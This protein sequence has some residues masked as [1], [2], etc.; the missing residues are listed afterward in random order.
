MT[1]SDG[2]EPKARIIY[3]GGGAHDRAALTTAFAEDGF[4]LIPHEG[5]TAPGA[6]RADIG[7]IDLRGKN[8]SSRKAQSI[9]AY[10][11][12][13]SPESV[14]LI[15]I[16]PYI[17][18]AA[19][20]ALRRHGELVAMLTKPE[21]LIERCRHVLRLRNI[22]E[23]SGE[24]L[25]TLATLNR[26]SDFP[27]ITAPAGPLSV[28]I[29]GEAGPTALAALNAMGAVSDHCVCVFS[30]GQALRA[31]E[32]SKF[33]C[34]VFLPTRDSDPLLGL[35]RSLR[36]HP[37][38]ATMPVI[39]P[40]NDPDHAADYVRR[41]AADFILSGHVATDLAI[42]MQLA[43]RRARLAKAM[44]RFL[45]ACAGDSVRDASSGA[46]TGTFLAEHGARLCSRA[47]QSGRRMSMIALRI[48]SSSRDNGEPEPGKRALHQAAHLINR[49]TRAEDFAARIAS[50]TFFIVMP[51]TR[52]GDAAKAALR[53]Q[54][55][56]EN[57]LFRSADDKL[58]Y[59]MRVEAAALGR[60]DGMS[61]E[62]CV[63]AGLNAL[64]DAAVTPLS[65]Q[66]PR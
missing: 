41:G 52:E 18:E 31:A 45:Q 25:K 47:D 14:I 12:K 29:A 38:H 39:F 60:D 6:V 27:P 49:V 28:L 11:R 56:L 1:G 13:I 58:L 21:G 23:E 7:L 66:S 43:A 35:A 37:K 24:R 42:K 30:A 17:G 44:R 51:A 62:E 10:L 20:K 3:V 53:V 19:R 55:V 4:L 64:K 2:A 8:V 34:A 5:A 48:R 54:A 50:D 32:N 36:R 57:T 61:I 26:L 59:G 40:I 16:D 46:F 9:A 22:A 33:D 15:V 63:A 65:Q